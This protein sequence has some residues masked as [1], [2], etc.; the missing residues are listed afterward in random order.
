SIARTENGS[1][2]PR[3]AWYGSSRRHKTGSVR[4]DDRS[5]S[6]SAGAD[7]ETGCATDNAIDAD[8]PDT[9]AWQSPAVP[10]AGPVLPGCRHNRE[11]QPWPG[12]PPIGTVFPGSAGSVDPPSP[13]AT[14]S[15]LAPHRIKKLQ[16][17]HQPL[18]TGDLLGWY[19]C[20]HPVGRPHEV[21]DP[22]VIASG[23]GVQR[24]G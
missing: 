5:V 13:H 18:N 23:E 12:F 17:G 14:A 24:P 20:G 21:P 3:P 1:R 11:W 8:Y 15:G 6:P 7:S 19:A 4:E 9:P 16:Y 22:F 10:Q 2:P